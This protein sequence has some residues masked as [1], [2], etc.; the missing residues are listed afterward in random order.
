M[1]Y[2]EIQRKKQEEK[3]DIIFRDGGKGQ[4]KGKER[5]FV[6]SIPELNLWEGIR[7]D[8]IEYFKNNKITWWESGNTPSGHLLSSQI[9][10][11]NHLYYIRH[12]KEI[13][14]AILQNM[15][16]GIKKALILDDGFVEFEK[17]GKT[18]LGKEKSCQRGANCTSIDAMMLG[19]TTEG[20]RIL[21]IIEWKYTESYNGENLAEGE[22]GQTRKD[23]YEALVN[24]PNSPIKPQYYYDLFYEPFYQMMRQTLFAWQIV[25]NREYN[26][27]EY[28][29]ID[30]IPKDNL[31]LRNKITS[32]N[33]QPLGNNISDVWRNVINDPTKY[34][35]T[36]PE[37]F[38]SPVAKL[39]DT[40]SFIRYL[41]KRYW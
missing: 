39:A 32:K 19:E 18:P 27:D 36:D 11:L 33:L 21:F 12:R 5:E 31:E 9:A 2:K 8:A 4:F 35:M 24:L 16:S 1:N 15:F 37:S 7:E 34:I 28:I 6:L 3:R 23:A 40:K 13:A 41:E 14:T 20:R 10:C 25:N 26:A 17:T 22:S 30:V 29:H 38:L